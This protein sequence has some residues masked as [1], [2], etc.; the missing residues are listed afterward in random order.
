MSSL[1]DLWLVSLVTFCLHKC[2]TALES[3]FSFRKI[4]ISQ[5]VLLS[6]NE[7]ERELLHGHRSDERG[8]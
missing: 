2:S 6:S 5:L 8:R 7:N 1:C 3:A 4:S